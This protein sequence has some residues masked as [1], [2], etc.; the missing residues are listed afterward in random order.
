MENHIPSIS[1]TL[2]ILYRYGSQSLKITLFFLFLLKPTIVSES[3]LLLTF[4]LT[5]SLSFFLCSSFT[6]S[7]LFLTYINST[8]SFTQCCVF[9]VKAV[10]FYFETIKFPAILEVECKEL[11]L[12]PSEPFQIQWLASI[13]CCLMFSGDCTWVT[14]L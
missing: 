4:L 9:A 7:T 2:N 14:H 8:S 5:F 3:V 12:P 6:K 10:L 1:I 11:L 13:Q